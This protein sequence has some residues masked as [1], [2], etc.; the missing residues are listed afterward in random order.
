MKWKSLAVSIAFVAGVVLAQGAMNYP[1]PPRQAPPLV[2]NMPLQDQGYS[3][4]SPP[5]KVAPNG[6]IESAY[7]PYY[8]PMPS[9]GGGGRF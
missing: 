7:A 9:P 4:S 2:Q 5:E 8:R 1:A 6:D 3:F